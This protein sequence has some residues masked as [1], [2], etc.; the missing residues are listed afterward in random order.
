[1]KLRKHT[2]EALAAARWDQA[3]DKILAALRESLPRV[4]ARYRDDDLRPLCD[5]A[6]Q[7]AGYYGLDS[8]H[9]AYVYAAAMLLYG[10]DFDLDPRF[11]RVKSILEDR[12]VDPV[13]KVKALEVEIAVDPGQRV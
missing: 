9:A 2:V 8:E 10:D 12:V 5:L 7:R 11:S 3:I 1:M 4:A 6:I 13:V